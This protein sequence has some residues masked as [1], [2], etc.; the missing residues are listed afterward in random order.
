[1][2]EKATRAHRN[3]AEEPEDEE[4]DE[5]EEEIKLTE[6]P[7]IGLSKRVTCSS[8]SFESERERDGR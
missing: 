2:F 4:E 1:L 8:G 7:V 6:A 5:E 3:K